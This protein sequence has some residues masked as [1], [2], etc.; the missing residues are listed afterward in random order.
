[1][2]LRSPNGQVINIKTYGLGGTQ[3]NTQQP[4][5]S[6]TKWTA[7]TNYEMVN[8]FFTTE[9]VPQPTYTS[10]M[11]NTYN[12]EKNLNVGAIIGSIPLSTTD[13]SESLLNND[14]GVTGKWTLYIKDQNPNITIPAPVVRYKDIGENLRVKFTSDLADSIRIGDLITVTLTGG[15]QF[16]SEIIDK[17]GS[18]PGAALILSTT[19][20][21]TIESNFVTLAAGFSNDKNNINYG[22]RNCVATAQTKSN[23]YADNKLIDW[24]IQFV[25]DVEVGAQISFPKTDGIDTGL[26]VVSDFRNVDWLSGIWTNG[27]LEKGNFGGGLWLNGIMKGNMGI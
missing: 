11:T 22:N 25:N 4:L 5:N 26:R 19:A 18:A 8:T 20:S 17:I 23:P 13:R 10:P 2:N 7:N 12:M 6:T 3:S 14:D 27:I 9:T 15:Y 24:E 16:E 21:T 1:M